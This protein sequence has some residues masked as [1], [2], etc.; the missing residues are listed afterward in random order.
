MDVSA[1]TH[2]TSKKIRGLGSQGW[3][4]PETAIAA[5]LVVATV[6]AYWGVNH[7]GF[8]SFDDNVYVTQN[9]QVTKGFT[10][11]G[12]KWAFT[13]FHAC[14][15]H[16]LTW[17]S[18]ML[19]IRLFGLHPT[20]HHLVNLLLHL[21][22]TVLL[23]WFL[24]LATSRL[25]PSA[26]VAA[27]F[28][29]HPLHVE[30]VAW[31]AERKDVLST[32]FLFVTMLA[33]VSYTKQPTRSR[34]LAVLLLFACGLM[35]K[36]MLVTLPVLLLLL[37]YWPLRR[38]ELASKHTLIM[39]KLPLAAMA[40]A[41]AVV[42]ILA[43][44][45]TISDLAEL[46]LTTRLTNASVSCWRYISAMF[47]P[48]GLAVHYPHP[49][50]P[51]YLQAAIVL[52]LLAAATILVIRVRN[53]RRY[54]FVGWAWF[55][56][57]LLPVIGILQVGNQSHADRYT[58]IPL[59]GLFIMIAW[60]AADPFIARPQFKLPAFIAAVVI[61]A[62][63]AFV[64]HRT[65][66]YWENDVTLYSRAI[67][68]SPKD[69]MMRAALAG[70]LVNGGDYVRA[71]Q[72]VKETLAIEP[73]NPG[74]TSLLGVILVEQGKLDEAEKAC[75]KALALDPNLALPHHTLGTLYGKRGLWENA[76]DEFTRTV[77]L[78][79]SSSS[80]GYLG[81]AYLALA[82]WRGAEASYRKA[83]LLGPDKPDGYY[84][85]AA[86]LDKQGRKAEAIEEIKKVL[87]IAPDDAEAKALLQKLTQP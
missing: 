36:P 75:R 20:G 61:L 44:R 13:T 43:Q 47:W 51:L 87:A 26:L 42:T 69:A 49:Q 14:N 50:E 73:D 58:Y 80:Y 46:D 32:L 19:D 4:L 41:S 29:L 48:V 71:E 85:L 55:I 31:I 9:P 18:H 1:K 76:I 35:S 33:Y 37:D 54:L 8:L 72:F 62:I 56:V 60:T 34:Y 65:V 15:W 67:D 2:T 81:N 64:T 6:A 27:L 63:M 77:E 39:E 74:A 11:A 78:Q 53:S 82:D 25:W 12:A 83:I 57:T 79:P 21:A 30:S 10:L 59:V 38:S 45:Q 16:P 86:V 70:A 28:A 23:F 52:L 22:N 5:G 24:T 3:R 68:I 66:G 7:N 40:A 17:L 84:N